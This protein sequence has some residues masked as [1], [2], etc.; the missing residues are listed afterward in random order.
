MLADNTASLDATNKQRC[1]GKLRLSRAVGTYLEVAG[2]RTNYRPNC[3][4]FTCQLVLVA[5]AQVLQDF[6]P[7][8]KSVCV[9]RGACPLGP[10]PPGSCGPAFRPQAHHSQ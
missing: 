8:G 4:L 7:G 2:Q 5:A 3:K 6:H 10:S 1:L 9:G